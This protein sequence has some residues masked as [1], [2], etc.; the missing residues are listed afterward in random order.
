M[1]AVRA[2][3]ALTGSAQSSPAARVAVIE[4]GGHFLPLDRPK[5]LQDFII[6]FGCG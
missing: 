5:E 1:A 2:S 4:N 3:A 6:G